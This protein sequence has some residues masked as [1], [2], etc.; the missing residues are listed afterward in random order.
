MNGKDSYYFS[1]LSLGNG[2]SQITV[3]S[4]LQDSKGFMWFGTRNG[5][6]R[7]DGYNFDVFVN[8]AEDNTSISDNH[9][10]CMTE[11]NNQNLWIGTNKGLNHLD[12]ATNKFKRYFFESNNPNSLYHN[13]IL[14]IFFDDQNNL[15]VGTNQGLNLYDPNTDSFHRIKID[16]LLDGNRVNAIVKDD[17]KLYIGTLSQGLIIYNLDNK[18]YKVYKNNPNNPYS[19]SDNYIK[20][21]LIDRNDNLWI[22]TQNKGVNYL[23]KGES[24]FIYY[25][26]SNGLTNNN[27][28]GLSEAPDGG[29][30]IGTFNG[31]N[32]IDNKTG[33]IIQYKEYSSGEGALSHYSILS[34]Y[35]DRSQTL[36]VG[37]YAGGVCYYNRYGQK[38]QFYNP[39]TNLKAILGIMGPIVETSNSL[40]IA[41]EGGGLLEMNKRT[42]AFNHYLIFDNVNK[43]YQKNIIKS[44]YYDGSRILCGTN[45]GTVYSF[46]INS[47][48]FILEYDI[49]EDRSIYQISKTIK[50]D[51]IISGVSEYG[52]ILIPENGNVI[53]EFPVKGKPNVRFSDVRN[54]VEIETNVFLIGTRNNGLFYY[55]YNKQIMKN[56]KNNPLENNPDEIPENFITSIV[57]DS[58]GHI[59]IGTY[60]GGICLFDLKSEKF[61]TYSTKDNLLNNNVCMVV[62]GD[63]RH[64]WVST[65]TGISDFNTDTRS[66]QNYTHSNDLRLDEF[67]LHAGLRLSNNNM[68]FSGSNG[69]VIFDPQRMTVNPNIPPIVFK[70]LYINNT[71]ILPGGSDGILKEQLNSQKEIILQYNQSN[72]SIEYSALNFI[73][74]DKNQYAYKLEG[75]DKEWNNVGSRRMAYYTNI[76]PGEY[77]F[78]VKGSNNDGI[79]NDEGTSIKIVVLSPLWKTWWAYTFYVLLIV[80]VVMFIIRYFT[81][82]KRLENDIKLKEIEARTQDEFHQARNKLFTNFSHE[83]RTPLTLIMNPLEDMVEKEDLSSKVKENM[84]LMR[85]NARRLLRLV[86]NLM[87]FQKKESGTM[88]L[89]ISENNIVKF[90]EEMVLF[91]RELALSRNIKFELNHNMEYV[92]TWFDK[93]LMEKVYFNLLSNAFKNVPNRGS[94]EVKLSN[95]SLLEIRSNF[96][97]RGRVF[98]DENIPYL[99]LEIKDSGVGIAPDELEKIF[100]PFYQ[101]AQNEHSASGTGLGLS[102]SKSIIEMHHGVIWAESPEGAGAVFKCVLPICKECFKNDSNVEEVIEEI[103]FP[104]S[105]DISTEKKAEEK[106]TGRKTTILVV[107]DNVEVRRYIISLLKDSHNIIEASNGSEAIDKAINHLPDLIISDLMMP[108]MDGMEMCKRIKTDFKTSHIPVIMIT[109]RAMTDDIKEGYEAG[110]DE[111]IVKPFNSDLL[112]TRVNNILQARENLK[113]IYGKRFSLETLGV[114]ATSIDER[115]MQKLYEI[116]EKNISNPELNLDDFSR[117]VGMSRA[118]LYRK[119]KAITNL[120]P[121]E[122]IRNF[123]LNMGAKMLKEARLPVSDVYVAVGFNSHAYFSNCFKTYFG[124]SPTEYTNQ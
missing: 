99:L 71:R 123:R 112:I 124:V 103:E 76:P 119:I 47:H 102:L 52:F 30:V 28:R 24:K 38:F 121:N 79:W 15:W 88:G 56:Y 108:K 95:I 6:N 59:W 114:E 106:K 41:T 115:F 70:N 60:G 77:R 90:T 117:D 50:G 34:V 74:A 2:L 93:S 83:L 64:L 29:I 40:F 75:F 110:A 85:S 7:F 44:L 89:K 91:F 18:Q 65:I 72:I 26:E 21:I 94:V 111:Y 31:L 87:D 80:A 53:K 109:A 45:I 17:N 92:D 100:I 42:G 20:S 104:Y 49:K 54:V 4:I 3:T 48:K 9:I 55:D 120:S 69:F 96:K 84:L 66:F 107:E 63:N 101:V 67:T 14:S 12:I 62:D 118:N 61:T 68:I 57:K 122:F 25:N 105:I 5:L 36:W 81:E 86:N 97:E 58:E 32:V 8:N 1:N 82:K 35:F 27:I 98:T 46:D 11:D 10:L 22:G 78:V 13:T 116:L 33:E 51:L 37:T 23:K 113:E 43:L 19:L 39:S 73:F 16:N